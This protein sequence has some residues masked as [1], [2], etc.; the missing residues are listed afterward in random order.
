MAVDPNDAMMND[1][2]VEGGMAGDAAGIVPGGVSEVRTWRH[3]YFRYRD[4]RAQS[5]RYLDEDLVEGAAQDR[6]R[7]LNDGYLSRNPRSSKNQLCEGEACG[8]SG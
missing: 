4:T 1:V 6:V 7:R 5:S 8:G 2:V 3:G